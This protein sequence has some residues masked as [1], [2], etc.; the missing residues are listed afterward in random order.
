M[1]TLLEIG[2]LAAITYLLWRCSR[3]LEEIAADPR[4]RDELV[5]AIRDFGEL[6]KKE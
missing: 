1:T 2:F 4:R 5:K 6:T 3:S